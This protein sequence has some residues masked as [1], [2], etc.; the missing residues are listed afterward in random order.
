MDEMAEDVHRLT[1]MVFLIGSYP[2]MTDMP[3]EAWTRLQFLLGYMS[4][5]L[6]RQKEELEDG[7]PPTS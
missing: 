4:D 2:T 3:V 1:E 6:K 5:R 7:P